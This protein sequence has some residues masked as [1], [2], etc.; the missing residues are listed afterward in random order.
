[1]YATQTFSYSSSFPCKILSEL[2][3][4]RLHPHQT[5]EGHARLLIASKNGISVVG[6]YSC[7]LQPHSLQK[8][9]S[10]TMC[11]NNVHLLNAGINEL[12]TTNMTLWIQMEPKHH[13]QRVFS[14]PE[15][16]A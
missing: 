10:L 3:D 12:N 4:I 14:P 13:N 15:E 16:D 2:S 8:L 5:Q 6:E 1:M 9:L 11:T 7:P